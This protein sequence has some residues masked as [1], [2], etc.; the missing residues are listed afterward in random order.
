[1]KLQYIHSLL[2]GPLWTPLLIQ[3]I[4]GNARW[5]PH[6]LPMARKEQQHDAVVPANRGGTPEIRVPEGFCPIL[7]NPRQTIQAVSILHQ[8]RCFMYVYVFCWSVD[9][10]CA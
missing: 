6:A 7:S 8:I 2:P 10:R 1:M 4:L 5:R 9:S 3:S